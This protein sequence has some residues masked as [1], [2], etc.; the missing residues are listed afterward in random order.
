MTDE[1]C[2]QIIAKNIKE[3]RAEACRERDALL[4]QVR[5]VEAHRDAAAR[6][7]TAAVRLFSCEGNW[8]DHSKE[9]VDSLAAYQLLYGKSAAAA[10]ETVVVQKPATPVRREMTVSWPDATVR[11][12]QEEL[13]AVQGVGTT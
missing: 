2:L 10:P 5:A 9:W 11:T 8:F 7:M 6:C 13:L 4:A 1:E 3:L 12:L